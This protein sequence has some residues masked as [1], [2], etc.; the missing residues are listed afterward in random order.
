VTWCR[1]PGG[2]PVC[3][4][5]LRHQFHL[6]KGPRLSPLQW[7]LTCPN[8]PSQYGE[9]AADL[10]TAVGATTLDNLRSIYS[11]SL[12]RELL[13][14][15]FKDDELKVEMSGS[16]S[17]PLPPHPDWVRLGTSFRARSSRTLSPPPRTPRSLA[18]SL[19]VRLCWRGC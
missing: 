8:P 1:P 13:P 14:M 7:S 12:A 6:Q 3:N 10:H 16:H 2:H 5:P 4:P 17:L 15:S 18:T 11:Q 19:C 9:S